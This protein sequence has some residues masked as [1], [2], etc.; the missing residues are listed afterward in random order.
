MRFN[1]VVIVGL[2]CI[3]GSLGLA[4]RRRRL[5]REVVGLSRL[6]AT[7]RRATQR[8]AIDWGTTDAASAVAGAELVVL[9]VPVG[10]IV[11]SAKRL[12]PLMAPGAILTDVG[13]SKGAI[14]SALDVWC[15]GRGTPFVGA[16]P[17]AG[18]DQQGIEAAQADL[19]DGS[20]CLLTPGPRTNRRALAR[21][22]QL[23][24]PLVGRVL[25]ISPAVHDRYLSSVSHMPH[26]VAFALA[27]SATPSARAIAPR[28]FLEATRIAKSDP[29]LWRDILLSNR[30]AVRRDIHRLRRQL[31][32]IDQWLSRRDATALMRFLRHAQTVRRAI[33]S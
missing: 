15:A 23:W 4:L 14:V 27:A 30:A 9:A 32:A 21:V 6:A 3:G 18:S 16:H 24:Q 1:R 26:V 33:P 17:L 10:A 29:A 22:Q 7:I 31:A 19:F 13:S 28:S 5:A 25:T 2:G 20:L 8:G 11:P 12:S